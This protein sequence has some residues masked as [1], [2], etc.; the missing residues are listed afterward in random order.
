MES[1]PNQFQPNHAGKTKKQT[2]FFPIYYNPFNSPLWDGYFLGS[3]SSP[4][5]DQDEL[6]IGLKRRLALNQ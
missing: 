3:G 5:P 6:T 2:G 4:L 1:S